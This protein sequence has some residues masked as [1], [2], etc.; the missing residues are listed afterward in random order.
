LLNPRTGALRPPL[1]P[2]PPGGRTEVIAGPH[3]DQFRPVATPA[4]VL[5][6]AGLVQA[7]QVESG[8]DRPARG[9]LG[10]AVD[11]HGHRHLRGPRRPLTARS[12]SALYDPPGPAADTSVVLRTAL[13]GAVHARWRLADVRAL[14]ATAPGL[15]H[16]RTRVSGAGDRQPYPEHEARKRLAAEWDRAVAFVAAHPVGPAADPAFQAGQENVAAAVAAV[17]RRAD[18]SPGRWAQGGGPAD[19]RVLDIACRLMLDAV[20]V[21]IELDTRRAGDLTGISRETARLALWRLAG[22]GWLHPSAAAAGVHGARWA[23]PM[24]S[25]SDRDKPG[26]ELSTPPV[27]PGLSQE[28]T[29]PGYPTLNYSAWRS[30]LT[31]RTRALRHDAL[32]HA[33]LG[34]HTARVY[35]ALTTTPADVLDLIGRT[36][37][38]RSRLSR[39]LDRLATYHLARTDRRGR[40][41]LRGRTHTS[42][43]RLGRAASALDVLGLLAARACRYAVER[44]AWAWWTDELAWRRAPAAV[45]QRAPGAGQLELVPAAGGPTRD[46][47]GRHPV[48]HRGRADYAVALAYLARDR[49]GRRQAS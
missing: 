33:G 28:N 13:C 18:A 49:G 5:T 41:Q 14:L 4:A 7:D 21:D 26:V 39:L 47:Y 46:N 44:A 36:G 22:D 42:G 48:D 25:R 24:P 19:R 3:A 17:Q 40:W 20:R 1:A 8:P 35:Q 23:L 2:H 45:K 6:F 34:H 10:L 30:H 16:V 15:E 9:R 31:H 38:S 32:T 29:R 12:R 11:E 37:Y 27:E 43:T